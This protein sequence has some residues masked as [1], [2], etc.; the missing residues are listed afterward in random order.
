VHQ[1]YAVQ[2]HS[3]YRNQ[4]PIYR[5]VESHFR[6]IVSLNDRYRYL[7]GFHWGEGNLETTSCYTSRGTNI[8]DLTD[9]LLCVC[10]C[11]GGG[12]KARQR[13]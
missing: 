3:V 10:V 12:F 4:L 9:G 8:L 6:L 1:I 2:L 5:T 13:R 7:V 11:G